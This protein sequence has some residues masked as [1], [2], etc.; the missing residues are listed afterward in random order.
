MRLVTE[1]ADG[2]ASESGSPQKPGIGAF[3]AAGFRY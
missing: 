2:A 1:A 3:S